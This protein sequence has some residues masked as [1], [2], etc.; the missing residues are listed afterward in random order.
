MLTTIHLRLLYVTG[1]T[2]NSD[3]Y[4]QHELPAPLPVA[5]I[6]EQ[7]RLPFEGDALTQAL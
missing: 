5:P 3:T 1:T 2:T 6:A 4:R 7:L